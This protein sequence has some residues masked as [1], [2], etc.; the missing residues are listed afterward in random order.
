MYV[1]AELRGAEE[2]ADVH[3]VPARVHDPG[4]P[5]RIGQP[6]GLHDGQR[7]HVRARQDRGALA[8]FQ[9][10]DD[11]GAAE[12]GDRIA[13][14][15]EFVRDELGG[16]VLLEAEFGMPVQLGVR[17]PDPVEFCLE[18]CQNCAAHAHRPLSGVWRPGWPGATGKA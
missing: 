5:R 10:A 18:A 6:R 11:A 17:V 9:D 8:V 7:V 12:A 14:R 3:I 15:G 2:R 1:P 4:H 16:L 13:E